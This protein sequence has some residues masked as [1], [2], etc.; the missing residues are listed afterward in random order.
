MRSP[1]FAASVLGTDIPF[2]VA[3]TVALLTMTAPD[4]LATTGVVLDAAN[5]TFTAPNPT[6][7]GVLVLDAAVLTVTA[8]EPSVSSGETILVLDTAEVAVSVPDI[9]IW[10]PDTIL[11]V[12]GNVNLYAPDPEVS[13]GFVTSATVPSYANAP[14][15]STSP[16]EH[17]RQTATV[18]NRL[19]Q[20]KGNTSGTFTLV[21]NVE[22]TY[23]R[24]DRLA[25]ES[26]MQLDA[27]TASAAAEKAAGTIFVLEA[28]RQARQ[29]LITHANDAADDRTFRFT[30]FS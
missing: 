5:V 29:W 30:V 6:V 12:S 21:P 16:K 25:P 10:Q 1:F 23:L 3:L 28:D 18:L 17:A 4:P 7:P 24:D 20:G 15:E 11:V 26:V 22:K 2:S 27:M 14:S 8:P 9:T 13:Y 19:M